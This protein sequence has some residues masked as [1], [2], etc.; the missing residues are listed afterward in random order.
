MSN[1]LLERMD[2]LW[3]EDMNIHKTDGKV[4]RIIKDESHPD[5][6]LALIQIQSVKCSPNFDIYSVI[7]E[8]LKERE[9]K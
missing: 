1:E 9:S 3:I 5:Y 2:E 4:K 6:G 8:A 7:T